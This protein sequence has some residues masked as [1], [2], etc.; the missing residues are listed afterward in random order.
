MEN[1]KNNQSN[2]ICTA[3]IHKSQFVKGQVRTNYDFFFFFFLNNKDEHMIEKM[4]RDLG[5]DKI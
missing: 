2:Y 4:Q 1:K 3:Y 5:L